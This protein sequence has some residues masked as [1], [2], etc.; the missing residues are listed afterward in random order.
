MAV[1][2]TGDLHGYQSITRFNEEQFPL[3]KE[4]TR[5]D[6]VIICGDFGLLWNDGHEEHRWLD[7]LERKP[8]TLLWID[9]NH[10]NFDMLARFPVR[11]WHGGKVQF[12]RENVIH[13]CRGSMFDID[14]KSVFA[15]GGA[16]SLDKWARIEGESWWAAEMPTAEEYEYGR[17]VLKQAKN[18]ADIILTHSAPSYLLKETL[19]FGGDAVTDYFEELWQTCTFK[20]W[21]SGH[22]HKDIVRAYKGEPKG[23]FH[24][25][26]NK[27]LRLNRNGTLSNFWVEPK[28]E[29]AHFLSFHQWQQF[30]REHGKL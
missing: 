18:H 5:E 27:I 23:Y 26:Y 16:N 21:F 7:W 20:H 24:Y 2:I 29:N 15:F 6:Y 19:G 4:L 8:F 1:Y 14:G 25:V 17:Q 12:I 10:E 28:I 30:M 3:Q 9:G 11:N 13:L 22:Y